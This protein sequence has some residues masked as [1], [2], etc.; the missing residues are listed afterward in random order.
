M[1]QTGLLRVHLP[2]VWAIRI[3]TPLEICGALSPTF[4]A[5]SFIADTPASAS[6]ESARPTPCDESARRPYGHPS[7]SGTA[8]P[9]RCGSC[10]RRW[11][12]AASPALWGTARQIPPYPIVP[13]G[14]RVVRPTPTLVQSDF[15][16]RHCYGPMLSLE[17]LGVYRVQQALA[18]YNLMPAQ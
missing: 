18:G 16:S 9:R 3:T 2:T 8:T 5:S 11:A 7:A 1:P 17:G 10:L 13:V 6:A 4:Q 14:S 15:M 12:I